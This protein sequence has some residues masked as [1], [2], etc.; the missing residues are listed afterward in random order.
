MLTKLKSVTE[1]YERKQALDKL[2]LI[3]HNLLHHRILKKEAICE[4]GVMDTKTLCSTHSPR[5]EE[6]YKTIKKGGGTIMNSYIDKVLEERRKSSFF[7]TE[8]QR[9]TLKPINK[10]L[11]NLHKNFPHLK[12]GEVLEYANANKLILPEGV[13]GL[14]V[15]PKLEKIDD[16]YVQA[17]NK[18]FHW[19]G[20]ISSFRNDCWIKLNPAHLRLSNRTNEKLQ[21]L[22]ENQKN[23][24]SDYLLVPV[25][26][27]PFYWSE[28]L[29]V[30]IV[31]KTYKEEEFGLGSLQILWIL[32]AHLEWFNKKD[33][34]A[35]LLVWC[36]ADEYSFRGVFEKKRV[37]HALSTTYLKVSPNH[38]EISFGASHISTFGTGYSFPSG[39]VF[40]L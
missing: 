29:S 8:E 31:R 13:E 14:I 30:A 33:K 26:L 12:T 16:S 20:R 18:T 36:P 17:L 34:E 11:D 3:Y 5:K 28:Y 9:Y 10:Q 27:G 32:L 22:A 25:T 40:K 19:I 38:N 37:K 24:K 39:F 4:V 21:E 15:V 6:S 1:C 35:W 2:D 7:S 23:L